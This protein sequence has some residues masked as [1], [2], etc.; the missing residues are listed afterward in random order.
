[1]SSCNVETLPSW[2]SFVSFKSD[3]LLL[4]IDLLA[5]GSCFSPSGSGTGMEKQS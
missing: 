2:S 5:A 4:G 3:L 1:M